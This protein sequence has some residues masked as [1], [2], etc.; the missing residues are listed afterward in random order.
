M[1]ASASGSPK[2]PRDG[3]L[4]K[5][6]KRVLR[7]DERV[8][9]RRRRRRVRPAQRIQPALTGRCIALQGCCLCRGRS[10][11]NTS[12]C[13]S[14]LTASAS[15]AASGAGR[16]ALAALDHVVPQR[17]ALA[18]AAVCRRQ[19][20]EAERLD[21][22]TPSDPVVPFSPASGA[23]LVRQIFRRR[24]ECSVS[25]SSA[26]PALRVHGEGVA[27]SRTKPCDTY[28]GFGQPG[29]RPRDPCS[30]VAQQLNAPASNTTRHS[31]RQR[32]PRSVLGIGLPLGV[33]C[34]AERASLIR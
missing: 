30:A 3:R 23:T 11:M 8:T 18:L 31:A 20:C 21:E 32:P 10:S 34:A 33:S 4:E 29:R 5:S 19:R 15:R 13:P 2:A 25:P 17:P 12:H 27:A 14:L 6:R 16:A 7:L 24:P 26:P 9:Y 1:R 22:R 28:G